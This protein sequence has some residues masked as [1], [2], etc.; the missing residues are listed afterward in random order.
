MFRTYGYDLG[1]YRQKLESGIQKNQE[2]RGP[3]ERKD[4]CI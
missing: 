1:L 4:M 3:P 2:K